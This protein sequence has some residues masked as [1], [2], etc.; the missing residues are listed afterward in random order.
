MKVCPKQLLLTLIVALSACQPGLKSVAEPMT[1]TVLFQGQQCG[2]QQASPAL[3]RIVDQKALQALATRLDMPW[4]FAAGVDFQR[5]LL[6]LLEMG[7]RPTTG[8]RLL[9]SDTAVAVNQA[10]AVLRLNWQQPPA[11]AMLAQMLTSPCLLLTLPRADYRVIEVVDDDGKR[12]L[13]LDLE[14]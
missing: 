2:R 12:R 10:T 14:R 4:P 7:Q 5:Q 3:T 6:L 11:D 13:A 1:A 9:L 8:Y